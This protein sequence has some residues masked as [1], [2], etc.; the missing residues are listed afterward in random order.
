MFIYGAGGHGRVILTAAIAAGLPVNSFFDD[1]P[2]NSKVHGVDVFS[3]SP[4][5]YP[6]EQIVIGIG[7]NGTRKKISGFIKHPFGNI[8]HP[9]ALIDSHVDFGIG[10]VIL[11]RSLLQTGVVLGN[12]IIVNTGAT[13]DHDCQIGDFVHVAPGAILCGGVKV[14]AGSFIGAGS[15]VVQNI[16][17]GCGCMIYAGSVVTRHVPDRAV[18]RGSPARVIRY[19]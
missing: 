19:N 12:H 3:Y 10:N 17:I 13:I 14:G 7:H 11:H 16:N 5:I 18:V 2:S 6:H 9:T 1:N 8:I 4:V 15:I